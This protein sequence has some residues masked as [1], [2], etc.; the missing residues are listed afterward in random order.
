VSGA[1]KGEAVC[2]MRF[3]KKAIAERTLCAHWCEIAVRFQ[4]IDAAGIVFFSKFFDYVHL[5]YEGFLADAGTPLPRVLQDGIWA[6]PL[7]H[8]EADYLAPVRFGAVLRVEL[9][10]AAVEQTEITLGWRIL[11]KESQ[12]PRAV[13]QTVHTFIDPRVMSRISVPSELSR[14]LEPIVISP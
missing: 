6:A 13:V 5:A 11:D 3:E 8:A 9:V 7:R 12:K 14:K 1:L 4:D 10:A 2:V